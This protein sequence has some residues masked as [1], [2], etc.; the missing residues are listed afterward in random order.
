MLG[1]GNFTFSVMKNTSYIPVYFVSVVKLLVGF[2]Y[3]MNSLL[4]NS[5]RIYDA[6]GVIWSYLTCSVKSR[7]VIKCEPF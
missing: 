3:V 6:L 7:C 2:A 4:K 5:P 1:T